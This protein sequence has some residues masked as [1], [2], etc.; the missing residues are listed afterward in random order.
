[1]EC[2]ELIL[3]QCRVKLA[4]DLAVPAV[5]ATATV[6]EDDAWLRVLSVLLRY[7][8]LHFVT[9]GIYSCVSVR[10]QHRWVGRQ[11]QGP[12]P[13]RQ[14]RHHLQEQQQ[15]SSAARS[16]KQQP[17][18]AIPASIEEIAPTAAAIAAGATWSSKQQQPLPVNTVRG[19]ADVCP[20]RCQRWVGHV[21]GS[22]VT[23]T[24]VRRPIT[25]LITAIATYHNH[26]IVRFNT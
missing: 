25:T 21:P 23:P 24:A 3:P 12:R 17:S 5:E 9:T 2:C 20:P 22:N 15:Q 1:M 11:Q 4:S 19:I 7:R 13:Q 16:S 10:L 26:R 18:S 14:Q 8:H 6:H